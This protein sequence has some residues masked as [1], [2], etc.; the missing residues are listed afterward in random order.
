MNI[1]LIVYIER[2]RTCR[3]TFDKRLNFNLFMGKNMKRIHSKKK[4]NLESFDVP[5]YKF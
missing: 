3:R 4:I 2:K 5:Q 1:F